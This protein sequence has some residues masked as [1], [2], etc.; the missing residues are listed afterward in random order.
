MN[1]EKIAT[2]ITKISFRLR[3]PGGEYTCKDCGIK[4]DFDTIFKQPWEHKPD[5][6]FAKIIEEDLE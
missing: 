2:R 6:P 5:C 3:G 4:G 1:F